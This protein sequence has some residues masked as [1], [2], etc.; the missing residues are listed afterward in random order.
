VAAPLRRRPKLNRRVPT[1]LR[2]EQIRQQRISTIKSKI[3]TMTVTIVLTIVIIT[4][5]IAEI[6]VL[7]MPPMVETT[8]PMITS[9]RRRSV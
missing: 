5:A 4:V 3:A 9:D 2:E 8:E 1:L 6:M 7:M